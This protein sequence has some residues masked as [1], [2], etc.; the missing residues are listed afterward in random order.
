MED[1]SK[2]LSSKS[3]PEL[4]AS[5]LSPLS[6]EVVESCSIQLPYPVNS[7]FR[8]RG[9]SCA[10]I[11][12]VAGNGSG[13]A[14]LFY[15][16][17]SPRYSLYEEQR[18]M[19]SRA[20]SSQERHAYRCKFAND[21]SVMRTDIH[22]SLDWSSE[23]M[24]EMCFGMSSEA[25]AVATSPGMLFLAE[26]LGMCSTRKTMRQ[27][28]F[29][30]AAIVFSPN[31]IESSKKTRELEDK[32][33]HVSYRMF[34]E[35]E[36]PGMF[37]AIGKDY[38]GMNEFA[39]TGTPTT[40]LVASEIENAAKK[41][42]EASGFN[43][44]EAFAEANEGRRT[45]MF[46]S[47]ASMLVLPGDPLEVREYVRNL[48]VRNPVTRAFRIHPSMSASPPIVRLLIER[49][50]VLPT[51]LAYTDIKQSISTGVPANEAVYSYGDT[52]L[53]DADSPDTVEMD[54][55][56]DRHLES[57]EELGVESYLDAI[58]SGVPLEDVLA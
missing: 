3:L 22:L 45:F 52:L 10:L 28:A 7:H 5:V 2:H 25:Y 18:R 4:A 36:H 16:I 1:I 15:G 51:F 57:Y 9:A 11:N 38:I 54:A 42:L 55:I 48:A 58:A 24:K 29:S 8:P 13:V 19:M 27:G 37:E 35:R 44:T 23:N 47:V 33:S 21:F 32:L 31:Y 26:E 6:E 53:Q 30:D 12:D 49:A 20:T 43:I 17:L 14:E 50:K 39:F 56:I 46:P 34:D 41:S 40:G